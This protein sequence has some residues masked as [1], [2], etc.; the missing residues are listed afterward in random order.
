MQMGTSTTE[1]KQSTAHKIWNLLTTIERRNMAVLLVLMVF[2]MALEMIGVGLVL[3]AFALVSQNNLALKYPA[4]QPVLQWLGNPN[5]QTIVVFGMCFLVAV[6]LFKS[7]FMTLL[8]WMQMRFS[9]GVKVQLSQRLFT[10]YLR[11]PYA[12][13]LQR[14][15]AELLLNVLHRVG[16]FIA[17]GVQPGLTLLTESLVLLGMCGLLL[18]F[19]PLGTLIVIGMFGIVVGGSHSFLRD[20]FKRWGTGVQYHEGLRIQHLQQGLSSVKDLKLLGREFNFLEQ[21]RVHN[22]QSASFEQKQATLQALPRLWLEFLA[23]F[24][25]VIL[26]V[27]MVSR[28]HS[29]ETVLPTLGL[30]AI[31]AFRLL[32]SVNR[33][34]NSVQLLRYGLAVTDILYAEFNLPSQEVAR[35][36]S[37][38]NH[39]FGEL[40]MDGVTFTYQGGA[41]PTLNNIFLT[42]KQGE[43][44]GFIG[45]S[46]AGKSTLVDILIGLLTPDAGE[47]RVDKINIQ[48]NLR[49][50][51]NQIGYVPQAIFLTDDT[52]RR[53]VA[54][55]LS[56]EQIDDA[57]VQR[58]IQA[59][60][61]ESYVATLPDGLE[62][63]VGERGIRLSGGQRQ[64]I[65]IARAIYHDPSVLVLDEATS[66]LDTA[67]DY[68]VMQ[69]VRAMQ[70]TKT[71]LI[72]A[73]RLSTVTHC[74]RL[75]RV[76]QGG[77]KVVSLA[78]L[79][80]SKSIVTAI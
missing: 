7:L 12:F 1:T 51:Q 4:L 55:G 59:A 31:A 64:R 35:I 72:I 56:D 62:T 68:E 53:N 10:L 74:D 27:S 23:V 17:H 79:R 19:E 42:I 73:H 26:V 63:I 3:P 28:G 57:A 49:N 58:G 44:V 71:I 48:E 29:L 39:K 65:G 32:P 34:Y 6:Y 25:L 78:T 40:E 67:I 30:F 20:Y 5:Q 36:H 33:L 50:W 11:Q 75:Y 2:G 61:L 47:V 76:E 54:F 8:T 70:G 80:D 45:G 43:S 37:P 60:Q 38:G 52:L 13:H 16:T 46:G 14:N 9:F 15:S 18:Y 22:E 24:S 66:S 77:V 41:K 69:A 21:Y